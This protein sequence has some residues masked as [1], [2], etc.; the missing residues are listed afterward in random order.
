MK[1]TMALV[2]TLFA[3]TAVRAEVT[4]EDIIE[5]VR[6][7]EALYENLDVVIHTEY[8]IGDREPA[9]FDQGAEVL[10]SSSRVHYVRQDGLFRLDRT[11]SSHDTERTLSLDRVRAY[12]G[13]TTRGVEGTKVANIIQGRQDDKDLVRP[14]M[15]LLR[16]TLHCKAPLSVYLTGTEAMRSH[17]DSHWEGDLSLRNTYL[18]EADFNGLRCHRVRITTHVPAGP[19]DDSFELWLAEDRN[20]LPIRRFGFTFRYSENVPIG[21]GVVT[22]LR[23][24]AP[25]IWFPTAAEMT[26]YDGIE[27]QR[28]GRRDRVA[29]RTTY[30][31]EEVSLTPRYNLA[32]FRDV[33]IPDGTAVYEVT[34]GKITRSYREGAPGAPGG[35]PIAIR[36]GRWVVLRV[37]LF[38]VLMIVARYVARRWRATRRAREL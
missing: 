10:K 34:D 19:P 35:K 30:A 29:N 27:L 9:Q 26:V 15:L 21:E 14:H 7:S 2:M 17:P 31:V 22:A 25:N 37:V 38:F 4:L 20:Y 18:G 8:E 11:G 6:R 16:N 13:G 1:T 32:Y 5:N 33:T 24:I 23:E 3:C 28:S 12:D 36:R